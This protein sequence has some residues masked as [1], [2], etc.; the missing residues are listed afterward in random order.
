MEWT[1]RSRGGFAAALL[2]LTL[3]LAPT[4]AEAD[5]T[6]MLRLLEVLQQNGTLDEAAYT[7]LRDAANAEA[8]PVSKG[9]ASVS[10]SQD[11]LEVDS[12]DGQF[13]FNVGGR[14]H[15]DMNIFDEDNLRLGNNTQVRRAR[16]D[17]GLTF[18]KD[19]Y[20]RLGIDWARNRTAL[21]GTYLR[22]DGVEDWRFVVGQ[23]KEA[24]G[25]ERLTSSNNI[26]FM[27]RAGIAVLTPGRSIGVGT[28][29]WGDNWTAAAG[30]FGSSQIFDTSEQ[31]D[32]SWGTSARV[33]WAPLL[34]Q[35]ENRVVHLGLAGGYR[36][37]S[38]GS[39]LRFA[40]RVGGTG[41]RLV[42]SGILDSVDSLSRV[43]AEAG[44]V[45]GPFSLQGE[46]IANF[47]NGRDGRSDSTL[48]GFYAY[49]SYVLTGE[50]RSYIRKRGFFGTV[51]PERR[52]GDGGFG[53]W[54][55]ALRFSQLDLSDVGSAAGRTTSMTAGLNWY[56]NSNVRFMANYTNV[57]DIAESEFDEAQPQI[58]QLR[59]QMNF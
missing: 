54:E 38:K 31:V 42:D 4:G 2:A 14:I 6:A 53:A 49:A 59:A 34:D 30:V 46:Y 55:V 3:V 39:E 13:K 21:R 27:E 18:F 51:T 48:Q 44:M 25:L 33:T 35:A 9:G 8:R 36:D 15:A 26:T 32:Q 23:F 19:W 11:G 58:F 22:Y 12:G 52:L 43:G 56:V 41:V 1:E 45:W 20:A 40:T 37:Y 24:F 29:T 16:L 7:A 17:F 57:F 50:S 47:V 28:S 10:M 5:D